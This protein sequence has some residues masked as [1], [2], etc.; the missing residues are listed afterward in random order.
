MTVTA[1]H[2]STDTWN[3]IVELLHADQWSV[4]YE[5]DNFDKGIDADLIVFEKN[6]ER[7][8]LGWDNWFEGEIYCST[9]RMEHLEKSVA[10]TFTK[11]PSEGALRTDIVNQYAN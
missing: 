5:Y 9:S 4:V 8:L 11:G 1:I 6:G 3:R 7:I 2:I 10:T